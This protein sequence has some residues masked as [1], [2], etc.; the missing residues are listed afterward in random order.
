MLETALKFHQ[1]VVLAPHVYPPSVSGDTTDSKGE[2]LV[3]RLTI[4]F[5]AYN[6]APGF[7]N[8]DT[9]HIFPVV[10]GEIGSSLATQTV[11]AKP[12]QG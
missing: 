2:R 8:N 7:C 6:K 9:C 11:S 4:S 1:Q 10:L 3:N 12:Q 5:G